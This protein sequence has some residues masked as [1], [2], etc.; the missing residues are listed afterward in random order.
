E[1]SLIDGLTVGANGV[2]EQQDPTNYT[3]FGGD[4]KYVV[5]NQFSLNGEVAHSNNIAASGS[6]FKIESAISPLSTV[7]LN[8]YYRTMDSGFSNITQSG[9]GREL[10]SVKYGGGLNFEPV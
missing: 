1:G 2:M 4:V 3:L 10:G 5:G 7:R 6:A 9:S 8:G